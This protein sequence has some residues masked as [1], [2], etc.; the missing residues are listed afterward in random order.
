MREIEQL[1]AVAK[2]Y[3]AEASKIVEA[4]PGLRSM[5]IGQVS[6][7]HRAQSLSPAGLAL[8]HYGSAAVRM[9]TLCEIAKSQPNDNYRKRF[10]DRSGNRKAGWSLSRIKANIAARPEEHLHFLLRD[11]IAHEEQGGAWTQR[12]AADRSAVLKITTIDTCDNAL[13]KIARG[14]K[15]S[16][17]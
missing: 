7:H 1:L 13:K 15:K 2:H 8:A 10:Y 14:L 9:V 5:T 6:S 3:I 17:P 4:N 12:V 11:N 16:S